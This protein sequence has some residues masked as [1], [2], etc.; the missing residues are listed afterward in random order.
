MHIF[1]LR[2]Q[3]K[4]CPEHFI[5]YNDSYC[6]KQAHPTHSQ[7]DYKNESLI[8]TLQLLYHIFKPQDCPPINKT[9]EHGLMSGNASTSGA[10]YSF[11]CDDGYSIDGQVTLIC[12]ESGQWNGSIPVCSRGKNESYLLLCTLL[13]INDFG[14]HKVDSLSF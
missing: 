11:Y 13:F 1:Q 12:N 7:G 9:F 4:D 14:V 10:A 6:A 5:N 2:K 3:P 8:N